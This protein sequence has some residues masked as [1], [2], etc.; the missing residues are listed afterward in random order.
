MRN[1]AKI[2]T[3]NAAFAPPCALFVTIA[4]LAYTLLLLL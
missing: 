2:A 1:A 3:N 4:I